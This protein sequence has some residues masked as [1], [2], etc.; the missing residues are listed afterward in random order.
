[1]SHFFFSMRDRGCARVCVCVCVQLATRTASAKQLS[2]AALATLGF[3]HFFLFNRIHGLK[4]SEWLLTSTTV[5]LQL[6]V[7]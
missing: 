3:M 6:Q 5:S 2:A 7:A 4:C 1:M